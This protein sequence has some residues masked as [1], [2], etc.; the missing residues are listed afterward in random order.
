MG[1]M[2]AILSNELSNGMETTVPHMATICLANPDIRQ[3]WV[4]ASAIQRTPSRALH[5]ILHRENTG[6]SQIDGSEFRNEISLKPCVAWDVP[7]SWINGIKLTSS[8]RH[9]KR[10]RKTSIHP[11]PLLP[12]PSYPPIPESSLRV[13]W[14]TSTA[15]TRNIVRELCIRN[16]F[17]LPLQCLLA[18][19]VF[20]FA[21]YLAV[22]LVFIIGSNFSPNVTLC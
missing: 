8:N 12:R 14:T 16:I 1:T 7:R 22:R 4:Q 21:L 20:A 17:V 2:F 5:T 11:P 9:E 18:N 15:I 3:V 13:T 6:T 19:Q 10:L